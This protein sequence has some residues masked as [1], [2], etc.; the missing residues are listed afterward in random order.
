MPS[1][2]DHCRWTIISL[3]LAWLV[4]VV[5]LGGACWA[6]EPD[7]ASAADPSGIDQV[8]HV[9]SD[10][11][12]TLQ[13]AFE[14]GL[15]NSRSLQIARYNPLQANEDY[16]K[17]KAIY[18][19]AVF[20]TGLAERTDR[21]TQSLLDGVPS[22]SALIEDRWQFQAGLRGRLP[23][24]GTLALYQEGGSYDS[25]SDYLSPNP[26]YQSR[27]MAVLEQ[28]LLK[29]IGDPEG[30]A[31]ID[32]ALLNRQIS[33]SAYHRDVADNL[34][35]IAQVYW[36]LYF[37]QNV[38]RVLK[39]SLERA[40]EVYRREKVRSEQGL[41]KPVDV[42]RAL[43][44]VNVRSSNL[45]RAENQAKVTLRQLWLS[46]APQKL[47]SSRETPDLVIKD[48]PRLDFLELTTPA[49]L[50][51]ALNNRQELAIARDTVEVRQQRLSVARHN[52]LPVLDLKASY[53]FSGLND[54]QR[55][56][57][58]DPYDDDYNNWRVQLDFEWPLGGRSAAA[59]KRKAEYE[60]H[61]SRAEMRLTA[62]RIA[63]EIN[64]VVDELGIAK[65]ELEATR[66]AMDAARRVMK[67]EEVLF[68]LGQKD[69][70]DLLTVQDYFGSA[71]KEYIRAQARYNMSLVSLSRVKGTILSDYGLSVQQEH[72]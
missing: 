67:G 50:S 38:V 59:D 24:G 7:L 1:F 47:F 49:V 25:T 11:V 10:R 53:G 72:Y 60:A 8:P 21:P 40:R 32:V 12:L 5:S 45:L 9:A 18:D 68:E 62:E 35:E 16:N 42:D 55:R 43:V 61:Q 54:S 17:A 19:P 52:Q 15:Q 6:G 13:S 4:T 63:Q 56:L 41:S 27:V 28:P 70:Q 69:N 34:M 29:G 36:Q 14:L 22:E 2:P 37:E 23:T 46:I 58:K 51:A 64:V 48:S 31:G 33:E 71:E 44:A 30:R 66:E 20:L 39:E 65:D 57:E 26:Q 3:H